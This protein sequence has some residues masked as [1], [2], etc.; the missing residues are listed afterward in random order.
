MTSCAASLQVGFHLLHEISL[1]MSELLLTA[2]F[3]TSIGSVEEGSKAPIWLPAS[4]GP[5]CRA[6]AS[7]QLTV[8]TTFPLARP[9]ST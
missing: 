7:H 4:T 3:A 5:P 9:L 2:D 1:P 6:E 8:T